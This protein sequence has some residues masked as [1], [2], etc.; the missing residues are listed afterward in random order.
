MKTNLKTII[1]RMRVISNLETKESKSNKELCVNADL[2]VITG[3]D[4]GEFLFE[5]TPCSSALYGFLDNL[6]SNILSAILVLMYGGRE[7]C[8][9]MFKAINEFEYI[10]RSKSKALHM[11]YEK[12]PRM[13]YID[14]GIKNLGVNNLDMFLEK[15]P[16][17]K[18]F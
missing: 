10:W 12:R 14:Q 7:G 17:K 3:A 8:R 13:E 15:F 4:L 11:I 5:P 2:P 18:E 16:Q 9:D 1:D 6:P